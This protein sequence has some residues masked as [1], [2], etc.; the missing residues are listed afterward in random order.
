MASH[1]QG[2]NLAHLAPALIAAQPHAQQ[3]GTG[4]SIL[5][6][7]VVAW[8][9]GREERTRCFSEGWCACESRLF[10]GEPSLEWW[11]LA[12]SM[13][14]TSEPL[15]AVRRRVSLAGL[16]LTGSMM[17]PSPSTRPLLA[18]QRR[19]AHNCLLLSAPQL[20]LHQR[21]MLLRLS[22]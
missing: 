14:P 16:V 12:Y 10:C 9:A 11:E 15:R 19:L 21:E 7:S 1:P 18:V 20:C 3:A 6:Q 8:G 2:S 22:S 13:S 5:S 4:S 17:L